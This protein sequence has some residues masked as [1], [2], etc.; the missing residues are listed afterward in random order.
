METAV[1]T[2]SNAA[3]SGICCICGTSDAETQNFTFYYGRKKGRTTSIKVSQSQFSQTIKHKEYEF[4]GSCI[5]TLCINCYRKSRRSVFYLFAFLLLATAVGSIILKFI[6]PYKGYPVILV[7][8]E[9]ILAFLMLGVYRD[10]NMG[11]FDISQQ[12]V[13]ENGSLALIKAK[14]KEFTNLGYNT[15]WTPNTYENIFKNQPPRC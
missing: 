12:N 3:N 11:K 6:I 10:M 1:N 8:V 13:S 5:D 9:L 4:G 15:F 2:D 7:A 14:R